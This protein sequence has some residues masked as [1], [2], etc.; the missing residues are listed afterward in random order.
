MRAREGEPQG[1]STGQSLPP[2]TES[3][4]LDDLRQLEPLQEELFPAEL[5]RIV[6]RL[7]RPVPVSGMGATSCCGRS[8]TH[9]ANLTVQLPRAGRRGPGRKMMVTPVG[10]SP[11]T[12]ILTIST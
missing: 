1:G 11:A 10:T 3:G 8:A 9:P 12:P 2:P 6:R 5:A 4:T 7:V